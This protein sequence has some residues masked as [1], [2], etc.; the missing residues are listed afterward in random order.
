MAKV[1]IRLQ[2]ALS[3]AA[4]GWRVFP[5]RPGTKKPYPCAYTDEAPVDQARKLARRDHW[6]VVVER[7][8]GGCHLASADPDTITS[9]WERWPDSDI[10]LATGPD[11][12]VFVLDADI[13]EAKGKNGY[14]TLRGYAESGLTLPKTVGQKTP[15]GGRH[16]LFRFPAGIDLPNSVERL[17]GDGLDTRT[18][19][20]YIVLPPSR[21]PV[22]QALYQWHPER[23]PEN[24]PLADAPQWLIDKLMSPPADK[25]PQDRPPEPRAY[26]VSL[27]SPRAR[28]AIDDECARVSGTPP[29]GQN[30]A[31]N[32]AAYYIGQLVGV[33]EIPHGY[34]EQQ[35]LAAALAM[36]RNYDPKRGKW[37]LPQLENRVT[38]GLKAG[39]ADK[40]KR[41]PAERRAPADAPPP[42]RPPA[43]DGRVGVAPGAIPGAAP[44]APKADTGGARRQQSQDAAR[45]TW[46]H[47][48]PLTDPRAPPAVLTYVAALG[49]GPGDVPPTVR[50][51]VA[52]YRHWAE[53]RMVELGPW[54]ALVAAVGA[55]KRVEGVLCT[56]IA[57]SG[58]ARQE[59]WDTAIT[60]Q[61]LFDRQG[62]GTVKGMP[63]RLTPMADGPLTLC[64][65]VELGL[66]ALAQ[67]GAAPLWA[68]RSLHAAAEMS[69]PDTV[70]RVVLCLWKQDA[71]PQALDRAVRHLANGGKRA[72]SVAHVPI[73]PGVKP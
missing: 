30:H 5:L 66:Y 1:D 2:A 67:R 49:L 14:R 35:L 17:L 9:W 43:A 39:I 46:A 55:D 45:R 73:P 57:P 12:G 52:P 19:G 59:V 65:G 58:R 71:P 13:D 16:W 63:L 47:A 56:F 72:V 20:G 51:A 64:I 24:L 25:P 68:A 36:S 32:S 34:A 18:H 54:P 41:K 7:G 62:L 33:G 69:L 38:E 27:I 10:G 4:R 29:G 53:G 31:L 6:P 42:R 26:D 23:S 15:S 8:R 28:K 50:A 3:Y 21:H 61:M 40:H 70:D 60:G 11:S 37:T 22:H 44:G 48:L